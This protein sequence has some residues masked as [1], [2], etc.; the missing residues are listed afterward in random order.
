MYNA[1]GIINPSN[2]HSWV[3]G[4]ETYRPSGAFSFMGRYR[5]IDFPI[6]NM[7]NS[8]IDRIQVYINRKPLS[9]TD[10][11]GSGRHYNINSKRGRLQVLFSENTAEH[12]IYNTD[13]SAY[14]ENIECIQRMH[15]PYVVIA[16]SYMVYTQDYSELIA[17]HVN[18]GAD[19]TLLYHS[20]D[21][22][23]DHY[24]SCNVLD[25]NRQKGVLAIEQNHGT[26]KSRNIFMDTY[27]MKTSLFIELIHK[28]K[29]MSSMYT[30]T[31][32]INYECSELDIRGMAHRGF[33]ASITDFQSYYDSNISLIDFKTAT[34]LFHEG[35]PI[36][37]KTNDSCPT[38]YFDTANV[39][40]SVVSNGCLIEGTIENSVIG[41]GCVVKKGSVVKNS[42]ILAGAVIGENVHVENQVVDKRAQL[43]RVK[44][45]VSNPSKPGYIKREDVL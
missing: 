30:L 6:S 13:I 8:G 15:H 7:S 23:K 35:W 37:T 21:N 1:F 41:R 16:P 12:D 17:S 32:I 9:L 28:A 38:Q 22:A 2:R 10:H 27:I 19:I 3:E 44:E 14:M 45:I 24:L 20:V 29:K 25:L 43:I 40:S 4:L 5:V 26:A 34:E 33:F 42:I 36:Y 39:T 31:D 18:S 11:L